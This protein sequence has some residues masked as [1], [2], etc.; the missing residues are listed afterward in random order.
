[1]GGEAWDS[2]ICNNFCLHF[3][4]FSFSALA[5]PTNLPFNYVLEAIFLWSLLFSL[6]RES[7]LTHPSKGPPPLLLSS[8]FPFGFLF[9]HTLVPV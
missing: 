7:P 4:L 8:F 2:C 9:F 1:M 3:L 5:V 6:S